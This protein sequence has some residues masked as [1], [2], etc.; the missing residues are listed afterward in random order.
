MDEVSKV[1]KVTGIRSLDL[2]S[3]EQSYAAGSATFD[4]LMEA[5]A[6]EGGRT[7]ADN[8]PTYIRVR[9][10]YD[11]V[12]AISHFKDAE[13]LKFAVIDDSMWQAFAFG[14]GHS[15]V[16]KGLADGT[17]DDELAYVTGHEQAHNAASHVEESEAITKARRAPSKDTGYRYKT[18]HINIAEQ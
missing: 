8:D 5:V 15:L 11:R 10:I 1:D 14:G 4:K 13:S 12:I 9:R 3:D 16:I 7:L 2:K 6:K 18:V 17:T